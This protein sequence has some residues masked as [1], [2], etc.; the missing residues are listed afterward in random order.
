MHLPPQITLSDFYPD[1]EIDKIKSYL[2]SKMRWN[3]CKHLFRRGIYRRERTPPQ[4][5]LH[6]ANMIPVPKV[7]NVYLLMLACLII[8]LMQGPNS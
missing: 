1:T 8:P 2:I 4:C 6:L 5:H 7:L 3:N